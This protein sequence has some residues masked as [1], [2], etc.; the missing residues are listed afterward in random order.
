MNRNDDENDHGDFD[1][2]AGDDGGD[3]GDN[4]NDQKVRPIQT[5]DLRN[6]LRVQN[7]AK[8]R[9]GFVLI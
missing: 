8:T 3:E 4:F 5:T 7:C 9:I 1:G 6:T 2:D